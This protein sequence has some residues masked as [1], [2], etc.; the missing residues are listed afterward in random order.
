MTIVDILA[1]VCIILFN[2]IRLFPSG[3]VIKSATLLLS[4]CAT[5]Y[6]PTHHSQVTEKAPTKKKTT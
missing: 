4:L 2:S 1:R 3:T 5:T 6:I